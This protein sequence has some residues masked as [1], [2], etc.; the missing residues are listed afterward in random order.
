MKYLIVVVFLLN[1]FQVYGSSNV[2][3]P[4]VQGLELN[5]DM[6]Q[7]VRQTNSPES[8]R[9][10]RELSLAER[11]RRKSIVE[12]SLNDAWQMYEDGDKGPLMNI[13]NRPGINGSE[14]IFGGS[15]LLIMAVSRDDIELVRA[16]LKLPEIDV[17][18]LGN[19][20]F[21][22][23]EISLSNLAMFNLLM[24][25]AQGLNLLAKNIFGINPIRQ[26]IK[27]NKFEMA[28]RMLNRVLMQEK[29]RD[30][31]IKMY[32]EYLTAICA[33]IESGISYKKVKI[34]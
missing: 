30:E 17:N 12:L 25:E 20:A 26:A 7:L 5:L 16:I 22:P 6:L 23:I 1:C 15:S 19:S 11:S 14:L 29:D 4:K 24:S 21:L 2:D 10:L 32:Q 27:E 8:L 13:L 3:Q 28:D 34:D 9:L 31:V 33:D 18:Y